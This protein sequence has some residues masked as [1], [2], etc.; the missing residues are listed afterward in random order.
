MS[1]FGPGSL[2]YHEGLRYQMNQVQLPP[3]E[4]HTRLEALGTGR[5]AEPVIALERGIE[6]E[7]QL[8]DSELSAELLPDDE[9]A[10]AL[11][12]EGAEGGAGVL[13]RLVDEDGAL[14]R[15]AR[16]A[17]ETCHFDPDTGADR[18]RPPS[19]PLGRSGHRDRHAGEG[20]PSAQRAGRF[21]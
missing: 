20:T 17:L 8:E 5:L 9:R 7:F 19:T 2:V 4:P 14:V 3:G 11:F 10:R 15:A 18:L 16:R 13:R 1:E 21:T 6:A 12:V